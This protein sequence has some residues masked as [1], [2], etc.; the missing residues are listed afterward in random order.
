MVMEFLNKA[1]STTTP[2]TNSQTTPR[3]GSAA[4]VEETM[5]SINTELRAQGGAYG[6][7]SCKTVSWDDVQRGTA[8]GSLSSLGANITDTRLWEKSGKQLFTVRSDNWNEKLGR[9]SADELALISGNQ[10]GEPLAPLTL[11]DFLSKVGKHGKYAGLDVDTDL[12]NTALDNAVSIRFQTTFLPVENASLAALEF[13]PEMYNYQT[14]SDAD[15]RN[16]L[17]LATTQ[18]VAIQQ[19]GAGAKKLFHHAVDPK[20]PESICRYWFEAERSRHAVG[21]AQ[22]ESR[23]EAIEAAARGKATAAVIGTR[24]MGTRFNVLMTIQVPLQQQ[25]RLSTR[26]GTKM[27][28]VWAPAALPGPV[29]SLELYSD[30]LLVQAHT[31]SKSKKKS[32]AP[33]MRSRSRASAAPAAQLRHG[34]ANAARVSRGTMVDRWAGLDVKKPKRDS[35]QHVTVTVVIYNTVAG[36]VP[37]PEDVRAAIEDMEQ[38]YASCGWNGRL[39]E[40]NTAFAAMTAEL[41]VGNVQQ[42]ATKVTTQPY[43]PPSGLVMGGDCFPVSAQ[44]P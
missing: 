21:G 25:R 22:S 5:R 38:L 18:G 20:A 16:L 37:S 40:S 7:Y 12:S 34:T 19:D 13:A 41:T 28:G 30:E 27:G 6:T 8:G 17:I 14:R 11:R 4:S 43:T 36:G 9:V 1:R 2:S 32:A 23:E 15:P 29:S 33:A 10:L 24:T 3:A 26:M 39:A 42:I 31:F 35:T 44:A